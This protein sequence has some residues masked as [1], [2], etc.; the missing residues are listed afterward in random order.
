MEVF[1]NINKYV[2]SVQMVHFQRVTAG[3][4]LPPRTVRN[5]S[6]VFITKGNGELI[7][8]GDLKK[9][10]TGTMFILVPGMIC[11]AKTS[12]EDPIEF[13]FLTFQYAAAYEEKEEWCFEDYKGESFPFSGQLMIQHPLPII[14]TL[15]KMYSNWEKKSKLSTYYVKTLFYQFFYEVMNDIRSQ[16]MEGD[17]RFS[18][19]QTLEY[20]STN[21]RNSITLQ[22]LATIAGMSIS[23]YSKL[24]KK[25]VGTTP[26]NYL[27][28]IRIDQAKKLLLLSENI[29]LKEVAKT[30]GYDDEFYFSRIFKKVEGYSP[31]EYLQ[32][33]RI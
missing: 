10:V 1:Q 22:D 18:I 7:I 8:N 28:K 12:D 24:F 6:I 29:R 20:I 16:R 33:Y 26:V 4:Y 15:E 31:T 11:S 5:H 21:Y 3:W 30:V 17:T 9:M 25:Y 19:E 14:Q 13:Y 23:Y 2:F 32:K 27:T